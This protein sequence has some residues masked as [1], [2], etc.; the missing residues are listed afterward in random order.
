M[1]VKDTPV[2]KYWEGYIKVC[3]EDKMRFRVRPSDL[4]QVF[5]RNLRSVRL[6]S[7]RP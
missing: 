3:C 4:E 7:P 6:E 1:N 5:A 2:K